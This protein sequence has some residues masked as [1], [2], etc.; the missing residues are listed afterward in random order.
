MFKKIRAWF[1]RRRIEHE[2]AEYERGRRW[3]HHEIVFGHGYDYVSATTYG[4]WNAFDR[5][6]YESLREHAL[7]QLMLGREVN[8]RTR[9]LAEE[10]ITYGG[11]FIDCRPKRVATSSTLERLARYPIVDLPSRF[12]DPDDQMEFERMLAR[13]FRNGQATKE[14]VVYRFPPKD[15]A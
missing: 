4:V 10:H 12:G 14:P 5:G 8:E 11:W 6:A 1:E 2:A 7:Q 9:E 3:A 13:T 15:G